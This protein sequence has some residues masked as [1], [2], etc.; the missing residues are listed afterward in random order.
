VIYTPPR[1]TFATDATGAERAIIGEH[2]AYLSEAFREG[3]LVLAGRTQDEPPMG[4][5][6]FRAAS[7]GA[8]REFVAGDPAVAKGVFAAE[9]R[10]YSI[11]LLAGR[12]VE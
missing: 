9:V 6:V 8:A 4:I 7:A 11:A 5:G 12:A 10:P 1:A 2:F 3:H